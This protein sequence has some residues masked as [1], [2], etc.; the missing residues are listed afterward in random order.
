MTWC[1]QSVAL[2]MLWAGISYPPA[3]YTLMGALVG[4]RLLPVVAAI[5]VG[6]VRYVCCW[7]VWLGW[8]GLT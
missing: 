5:L 8:V 4:M 7:A 1:M 6:I 2:T 3:A